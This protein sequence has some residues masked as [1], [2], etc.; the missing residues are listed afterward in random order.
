MAG[1]RLHH[2]TLRSS[3]GSTVTYVVELPQPYPVVQ[4]CPNCGKEHANKAIHLRLDGQGD[5]IVSVEVFEALR[6]AFFGGMELVNEIASPPP[7]RI[8]AVDKDKERIVES[9][10]RAQ[11]AATKINPA[12]TKYQ[13]RD[14]IQ[15]P[16]V[17]VIERLQERL[18]REEA[19]RLREK[20]SMFIIEKG[21]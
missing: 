20:R 5:V 14:R 11:D 18:D 10:L 8:G 9:P 3:E 17:P 19:A 12:E 7:L 6:T 13:G 16:F 1:L 15:A 21:T 4:S 2:P